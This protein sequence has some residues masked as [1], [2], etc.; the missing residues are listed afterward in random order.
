MLCTLFKYKK[1]TST[2]WIGSTGNK[3]AKNEYANHGHGGLH[4]GFV[5][6][7]GMIARLDLPVNEYPYKEEYVEE[8]MFEC[9]KNCNCEK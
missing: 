4:S 9:C 5:P 6:N 8:P 7:Q 1:I 2:H 3:Y